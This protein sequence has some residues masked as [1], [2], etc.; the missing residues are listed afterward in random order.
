MRVSKI[1]VKHLFNTFDHS[2]SLNLNSRITIIHGL[3]G[4]GKTTILKMV[5]SLCKARYSEFRAIPFA[6]LRLD[7][8]DTTSITVTKTPEKEEEGRRTYGLLICHFQDGKKTNEFKPSRRVDTHNEAIDWLNRRV[9]G[10]DRMSGTRWRYHPTRE[11]LSTEEVFERFGELLPP[12]LIPMPKDSPEWLQRISKD[13][14]VRLIETQRLVIPAWTCTFRIRR[15][16]ALPCDCYA[17]SRP[18]GKN[19]RTGK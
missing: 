5:K 16:R 12:Q 17:F 11:L 13:I 15:N 6:E 18:C 4:L 2:I 9:P 3:N 14:E 19:L 1:S 7:F 10:L 8:D